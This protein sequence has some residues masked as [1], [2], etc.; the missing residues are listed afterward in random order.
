MQKGAHT[1]MNPACVPTPAVTTYQC[2][3]LFLSQLVSLADR[4]NWL[5][6]KV[7]GSPKEGYSFREKSTLVLPE[8]VLKFRLRRRH[9]IAID[10]LLAQLK[11]DQSDPNALRLHF[12]TLQADIPQKDKK[13]VHWDNDLERERFLTAEKKKAIVRKIQQDGFTMLLNSAEGNATS[14]RIYWLPFLRSAS[15]SRRSILSFVSLHEDQ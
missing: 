10:Q 1:A 14:Q 7:P 8:T 11:A 5:V 15:M 3:K 9:S 12:L 6:E 2:C 13:N 4:N